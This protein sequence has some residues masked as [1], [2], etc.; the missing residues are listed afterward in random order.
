[1]MDFEKIR[2]VATF[3]RDFEREDAL[4]MAERHM[5]TEDEIFKKRFKEH[6][7]LSKRWE[8]ARAV[9]ARRPLMTSDEFKEC[10][11]GYPKIYRVRPQ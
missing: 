3:N 11:E 10:R 9:A 5:E 2:V 7:E 8:W 4:R 6:L 1:M